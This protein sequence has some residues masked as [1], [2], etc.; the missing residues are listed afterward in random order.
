[1]TGD[2]KAWL[3]NE[4][5]Y[6]QVKLKYPLCISHSN[7]DQQL[8]GGI[9]N[10]FSRQYLFPCRHAQNDVIQ[11]KFKYFYFNENS[12]NA[13]KWFKVGNKRTLIPFTCKYNILTFFMSTKIKTFFVVTLLTFFFHPDVQT[14]HFIKTSDLWPPSAILLHYRWTYHSVP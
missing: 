9:S 7:F 10:L 14:Y 5:T 2:E 11:V 4:I 6:T 12:N 8:A 1:M 3:R 13:F